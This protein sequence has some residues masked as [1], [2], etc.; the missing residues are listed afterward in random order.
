M[1][2]LF[3]QSVIRIS[4]ALLLIRDI[5]NQKGIFLTLLLKL[6]IFLVL[7]VAFDW[8]ASNCLT[9]G[10][11]R[12]FGFDTPAKVLCVGHSHTALGI[13]KVALEKQLAVPIAKYARAGANAADRF[14]MI[15]HYLERQPESVEVIVYD[16]D[17]YT[18]T[19]KG[20]SLNSYTLF[21]PFMD[22]SS[23]DSYVRQNATFLD[24]CLRKYVKLTRFDEQTLNFSIRG[25]F[26]IYKNL[27][28]GTV[29][30]ERIEKEIE[31]SNFRR[32]SFDKEC[33]DFFEETIK[34]L[35]DQHI[36]LVLLYIPTVDIYNQA[37]PK[38]YRKAIRLLE[39]YAAKDK[40]ITFLNYNSAL[41]HRHELFYDPIHLNPEGQRIVTERL[42]DD[43]K[44]ILTATTNTSQRA[45]KDSK[46]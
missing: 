17:A 25:W 15:K 13:D 1:R 29:D 3:I 45:L 33:I 40:G 42:A 4:K 41:S 36:Y 9:R 30:I 7:F 21:Y 31:N 32:I 27:K 6:A 14:V 10:L 2:I 23:V 46:G 24:Y 37:E 8:A 22:S 16:V 34:Y 35:R 26:R 12:T 20:L 18:F 19:G 5:Q 43:I 28:R 39:A 11:E 44:S 38:K